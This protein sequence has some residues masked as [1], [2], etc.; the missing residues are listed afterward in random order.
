MEHV[1]DGVGLGL[2]FFS[3]SNSPSLS[4]LLSLSPLSLFSRSPSLG[5]DLSPPGKWLSVQALWRNLEAVFS[6]PDTARGFP[7]EAVKF[8]A[9]HSSWCKLM[10]V[11]SETKNV[12][13]VNTT[14]HLNM[15]VQKACN[16]ILQNS[17]KVLHI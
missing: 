6:N 11:V 16:M 5:I 15:Q 3:S 8:T 13:Q 12:L 10:R 2:S 14:K 9:I 4:N 7:E 1:H 17:S